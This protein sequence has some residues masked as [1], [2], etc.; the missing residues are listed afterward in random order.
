MPR[1]RLPVAAIAA[2]SILLGER[3]SAATDPYAAWFEAGRCAAFDKSSNQQ[4]P[5]VK[6]GQDDLVVTI[7]VAMQKSLAVWYLYDP[8]AGIAY[9]RVG[10]DSGI[11]KTV[12]LAGK[13]PASVPETDLHG[14]HTQS[15][16]KL[17]TSAATVVATLG[18]PYVVKGCGLERY[19]Y[20]RV[21]E[22]APD[23]IAFTI[24]NGRVVEILSTLDG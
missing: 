2:L 11:T 14:S 23:E 5:Y 3:A 21:R 15:G 1:A 8:K 4:L 7:P 20:A 24:R 22:G 19:E 10:L 18:K 9:R 12:R 16:L 6:S 17:G 13:P